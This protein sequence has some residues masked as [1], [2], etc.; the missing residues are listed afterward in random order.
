MSEL[1]SPRN[2]KES[3]AETRARLI[4]VGREH[5]VRFG[6]GGAVAE[7]IAAEA[8]Y[9]RG[10]LYA[11]FE[12]LEA[13]F[14][15]VVQSTK[16][17]ERQKF[18]AILENGGTVEDRFGMMREAVGDLVTR[19]AWVVLEAEFQANALRNEK[20]REAFLAQQELRRREGGVLMGQFA[21]R[22]GLTLS[23][24]PEEVVAVL[25]SLVEGLAVRQAISGQVNPEKAKRMAMLCFDRL[26]TVGRLETSTTAG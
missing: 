15:A 20:I 22:L 23:S 4:A 2:R 1:T 16:D 21:S 24:S 19:P 11:N 5:F 17:A 7:K 3:Q 25:M 13:L 8:G 14:V 12:N 6:L 9:T 18:Q 10:A 26:V